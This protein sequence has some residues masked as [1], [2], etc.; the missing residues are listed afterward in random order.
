M[1]NIKKYRKMFG[2]TQSELGIEIGVSKNTIS[3]WEKGILEPNLKHIKE[4]LRIFC[5]NFEN[6]F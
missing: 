4:L 3:L 1:N 2:Y 5:T 6:L